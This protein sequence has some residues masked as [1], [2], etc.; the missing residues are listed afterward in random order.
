MTKECKDGIINIPNPHGVVKK[1]IKILFVGSIGA[2]R[3]VFLRRLEQGYF[4]ECSKP[5]IG[6]DF[7]SKSIQWDENT[8]IDLQPWDVSG[9]ELYN[10]IMTKIYYQESSGACVFF[11]VSSLESQL[12][13]AKQWKEDIDLQVFTSEKKPI[14]CLLVASKCDLVDDNE[15]SLKEDY[16]KSFV[17]ENH[18]IGYIKTSSRNGAN[19]KETIDYIIRYILDNNIEP[20]IV[21]DAETD[22]LNN[23]THQEAKHSKC[24]IY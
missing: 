11:D 24:L 6:V 3:T 17:E 19:I 4:N 18:F 22:T 10:S 9:Q 5:T 8:M 14:P 15:L 2:G 1:S 23:P 7:F 16:I 21:N 12:E 20:Y 13:I